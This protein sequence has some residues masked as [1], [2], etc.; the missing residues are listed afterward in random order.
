M[1]KILLIVLSIVHVAACAP[2]TQQEKQSLAKPIDCRTAEGDLRLL[3]SEKANVAQQIANGLTAI[4]PAGAIIGIISGTES[5]KF[6]VATGDYNNMIDQKIA[7]I[8]TKCNLQYPALGRMH[9]NNMVKL[10]GTAEHSK[11]MSK[12][13]EAFRS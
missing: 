11:F 10:Y 4:V 9:H 3:Q 12:G 1:Q 2:I 6:K 7:E 5:D 13:V 8:K